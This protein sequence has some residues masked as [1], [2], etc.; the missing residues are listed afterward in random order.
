[1]IEIDLRLGN[2]IEHNYDETDRTSS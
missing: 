1:M 2:L